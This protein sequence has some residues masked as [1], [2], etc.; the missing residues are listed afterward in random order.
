MRIIMLLFLALLPGH[1][2][3]WAQQSYAHC[4]GDTCVIFSDALLRDPFNF[5]EYP[6]Q[7]LEKRGLNM[8]VF[9]VSNRH[10]ASQTDTLKILSGYGDTFTLYQ[11]AHRHA[12]LMTAVL[13]GNQTGTRHGF[14]NGIAADRIY[15]R[16]ATYLDT[17]RP[18]LLILEGMESS[19]SLALF[20]QAGILVRIE[21]DGAVD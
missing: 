18:T 11:P 12:M 8:Q 19:A 21:Y 9:S 10:D 3:L 6:L 20:F 15:Q 4:Q 13:H 5:G 1:C 2:G 16:F 17:S 7:A 14:L